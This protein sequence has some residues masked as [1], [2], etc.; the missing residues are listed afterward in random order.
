MNLSEKIL[1]RMMTKPKGTIYT[2]SDFLDLGSLESIRKSFSRLA[3]NKS[4]Y[5][6]IEGYYTIPYY[7][8]L[9]DEI[10][11]PTAN[12]LASKIASKYGW[13]I[14]PSGD[15]AL[16]NV[17][18]STQVPTVVEYI[19]DGP[20]RT[21]NYLNHVIKFKHTSNKMISKYSISLGL[22]I[23][24]I[25]AISKDNVSDSDIDVLSKYCSNHVKEDLIQDTKSLP[26]WI[27]N[28]LKRIYEV[29]NE[30]K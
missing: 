1:T 17:G 23:E 11:Y 12:D 16:N 19:S 20:Y 25:K 8:E 15:I 30:N 13:N 6:L 10:A 24:S 29:N 18:L 2:G 7:S 4:V 27:Y 21:F 22:V 14:C 9:L 5:R 28:T 3:N 26:E